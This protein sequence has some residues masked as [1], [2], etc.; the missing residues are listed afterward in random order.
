MNPARP[1]VSSSTGS[2]VPPGPLTLT[3]SGL[4]AGT[5]GFALFNDRTPYPTPRLVTYHLDIPVWSSLDFATP[6]ISVPWT[7]DAM[8]RAALSLQWPGGTTWLLATQALT[9]GPTS[10][11]GLATSET[12]ALQLL[13]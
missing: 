2:Q 4:P 10:R 11:G 7:T 1:R 13:R 5:M 8:G 3:W 6:P 9:I 12:V